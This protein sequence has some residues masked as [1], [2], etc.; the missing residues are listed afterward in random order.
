MIFITIIKISYIFIMVWD[1]FAVAF[2]RKE[3]KVFSQRFAKIIFGSYINIEDLKSSQSF[4]GFNLPNLWQNAFQIF[5]I[6]LNFAN[7]CEKTL[8]SLR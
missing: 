5:V 3:R 8:R 7:L 6:K 2:Y 4:V 1:D